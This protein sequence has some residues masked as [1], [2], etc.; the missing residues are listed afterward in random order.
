ML[1]LTSLVFSFFVGGVIGALGFTSLGYV[2]T[3]PIVVLL[4]GSA[5][6]TAY[7]DLTVAWRRSKDV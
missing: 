2:L 3:V 6:V 1:V 7:D 5:G 4:I